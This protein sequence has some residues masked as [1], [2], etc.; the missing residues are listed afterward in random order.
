[1]AGVGDAPALMC[2]LQSLPSWATATLSTSRFGCEGFLCSVS[3]QSIPLSLL[4]TVCV[5]SNLFSW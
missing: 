1:M 2:Y 4:E 5:L 3:A